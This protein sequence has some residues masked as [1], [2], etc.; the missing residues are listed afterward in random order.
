MGKGRILYP[1][2]RSIAKALLYEQ[3]L[4]AAINQKTHFTPIQKHQKGFPK[5]AGLGRLSIR[6]ENG[7]KFRKLCS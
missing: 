7:S 5:F 3:Y 4:A 1:N 2:I 6:K